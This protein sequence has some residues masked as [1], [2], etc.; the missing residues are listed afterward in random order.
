MKNSIYI[1]P[2]QVSLMP[3]RHKDARMSGCGIASLTKSS[4]D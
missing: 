1:D 3:S 2:M 4:L